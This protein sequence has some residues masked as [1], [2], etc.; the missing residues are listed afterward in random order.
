[1]TEGEM[2]QA[3]ARLRGLIAKPPWTQCP[4]DQRVHLFTELQ[5]LQLERQRVLPKR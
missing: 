4:A 1:M 2:A 5:L 3:F